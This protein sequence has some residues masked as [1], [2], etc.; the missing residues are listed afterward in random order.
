MDINK[1]N[2]LFIVDGHSMIYRAY[3]ALIRRPLLNKKG[4]N[5]SAIYGFLRI[6]FHMLKKFSPRYMIISFDTGKP[7]FRHKMYKEYKATRKKM[8]EDMA[9]QIP[10]IKDAVKFLGIPQIEIENFESDDVIAYLSKKF[11]KEKNIYIL[12]RDK[13]LLQLI[14]DKIKIIQPET[15]SSK[16]EFT[17]ITEK[18]VKEKYGIEP[19]YIIDYLSLTGDT[20]DNIPGVKGI[21]PVAAT[22]LIQEFHTI[23]NLYNNIDKITNK[24]IREKLLNSKENAFLSKSLIKLANNDIDLKINLNDMELKAPDKEKILKLFDELDIKSLLKEID[25]LET[26]N[27]VNNYKLITD[28]EDFNNFIKELKKSELIS[29]DT[30]TDNQHP[31]QAN[32]VGLSFSLKEKEAYYIPVAHKDFFSAKQLDKNLILNSL[33][34]IFENKKYKLI[35]QNIKYDYIVMKRNGIKLKNIYFDTMIASYIINP[36]RTRHNLDELAMQYLGYKMISY[37]EVIG[38]KKDFSDVSITEACKYSGEDADIT[39]RL[40]NILN[41]QLKELK[42]EK[43]FY[44]IDIPLIKVLAEMEM[45]G[46]KIDTLKLAK[47]SKDISKQLQDL[48]LKIYK[49]AGEMFNINSTK[50]LA[51]ILFDKLKLPSTKKGKSGAKST[52]VEVLNEL[53]N[54]H[55]IA[56]YLLEYRT[57]NKLITTYIDVLPKMINPETGRIHTSFNQTVTATGRLSSS[58]PN[59]Q[60]IPVRD[61]IGKKI[62]E[63]FIAEK[64]NYI[65]SAD[66]SQIEL[67]ILAHIANDKVL[68]NAF[69]NDEDIHTRTV[70]ELYNLKKE[71][72]TPEL[73]RMAKVI[74]YG[75]I[76]GMSA[77][78]LSK[79]LN[80]PVSEAQQFIENYF[81]KYKGIKQYIENIKKAI[82]KKGY[83]E[84]LFGR[85]R[86]LPDLKGTSTQQ[87]NFIIRTATNTPIQGTAA[88][89]IKLAMIEIHNYFSEKNIKSK[90]LLQVHD[91]LVFEVIPEELEIVQKI[92]KEKMEN[93]YK[94]KVPIKVDIGYGKNWA[95][96]H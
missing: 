88:D 78:G 25:W 17:L 15:K 95:E 77:Y 96:A 71:E 7:N 84:N 43:L 22:K 26:E 91:E 3:Y 60:N 74:N 85:R 1:D 44:Q 28:K 37:K 49:E 18:E 73:R 72:V 76:Y 61:A 10:Y 46:I 40:F 35:G 70:M 30:E 8:P 63:A 54:I 36:T 53:K 66:Y 55:P 29:F 14:N 13:D 59:L 67:R 83:I 12:T 2:S 86:Y 75:V 80:I 6:L 90:M 68:I 24:S 92:I 79:E 69:N 87:R 81:N 33:K 21:G 41:K 57:L 5:T 51:H 23:E 39:L 56:Q 89:L 42:L 64:N 31:V 47:L 93:V 20:S 9:Y 58:D 19:Q 65:L 45:N 52:D 48:T 50:Q 34:E 62:R 38:K 94:F 16:E 27:V 82:E 4:M 11:S 32:L